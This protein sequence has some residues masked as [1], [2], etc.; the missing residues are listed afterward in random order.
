MPSVE[1]VAIE[2]ELSAFDVALGSLERITR[3]AIPWAY[4]R[5]SSRCIIVYVTLLPFRCG[6]AP[7]GAW[8][9]WEFT[10]C[11]LAACWWGVGVGGG[12][13]DKCSCND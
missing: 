5:H 10:V 3:Q 11:A 2:A 12:S 6:D 1:R 8:C 7:P 13:G 9:A 4:T